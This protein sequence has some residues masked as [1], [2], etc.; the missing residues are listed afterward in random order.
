MIKIIKDLRG[1]PYMVDDYKGVEHGD[2]IIIAGSQFLNLKFEVRE[3]RFIIENYGSEQAIIQMKNLFD[4]G[5]G[6]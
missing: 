6:T 4:P 3:L 5:G 2:D 1:E